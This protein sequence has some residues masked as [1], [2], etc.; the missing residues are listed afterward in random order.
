MNIKDYIPS[1]NDFHATYR[2]CSL[3]IM[4]PIYFTS[5]ILLS[6]IFLIILLLPTDYDLIVNYIILGNQPLI[7]RLKILYQILPL[8]G[9]YTYSILTD[10]LFYIVSL[11][12]SLNIILVLYHFT[13]HNISLTNSKGG[14]V[15]T[16]IA[17]VGSGCASCGS[18]LIV[19]I[20]SL[21]GLGGLL[22]ALPLEGAEFLILAIIVTTYSTIW[23]C[24]GLRG[25]EVRG[26]PID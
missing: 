1:R 4:H 9:S 2:I 17:I 14:T 13:Q 11:A 20:F 23:I 26:C 16:V 3:V 25:G 5:W 21:F 10:V 18:A 15:A 7:D 24:K 8:T 19:G 12:V 6:P 22:T